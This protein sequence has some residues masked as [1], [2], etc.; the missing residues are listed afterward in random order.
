MPHNITPTPT[1][2]T[3]TAAVYTLSSPHEGQITFLSSE[4]TSLKNLPILLKNRRN[5]WKI[6]IYLTWYKDLWQARRDSNPHPSVL[7]T[8]ALPLELRACIFEISKSRQ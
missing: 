3:N 2:A 7:E 1:M 5:P 6:F 8:A 4:R